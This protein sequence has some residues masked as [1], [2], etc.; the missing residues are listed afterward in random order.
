MTLKE[1]RKA[2]N[3]TQS[4]CASYLGIPLR[5]YQNYETIASK[6]NSL[7]YLY[8]QQR[9]EKYS[10]VDEE[11]GIL[12][13]KKIIEVTTSIFKD[14]DVKYCYLFGSY[15]KNN[16]KENNDIDLL[17]KTSISGLK[18]YE[19]TEKLREELKKKVDVLNFE[20]ITNNP[21]LLNEILRDGIKIYG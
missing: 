12:S 7:K 2:N 3:L 19:M 6:A 4:Q 11:N 1:L 18:Y 13:I 8:M 21:N 5:T 15:A 9:L 16:P 17:V 10:Y 20:Q 14:L